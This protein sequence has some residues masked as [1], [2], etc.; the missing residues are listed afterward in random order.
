MKPKDNQR[1]IH[2]IEIKYCADTL[3]PTSRKGEQH[4]LLMSR[5]LGHRK[6]LHT[7]ILLGATGTI[8]SNHT[9]NPLHSL[10]V[11]GLHAAP[12]IKTSR[13]GLSE[14]QNGYGFCMLLGYG[15]PDWQ[16]PSSALIFQS[17]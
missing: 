11:T 8:Y 17:S 2:L 6:A 15:P 1:D 12:L 5:L 4:K 10:G 7:T 16:V 9:R 3:L 14:V 13:R